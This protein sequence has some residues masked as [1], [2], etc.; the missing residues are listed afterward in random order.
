V[1]VCE[2][3]NRKNEANRKKKFDREGNPLRDE[4]GERENDKKK[5]RATSSYLE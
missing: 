1:R 2:K 4:E 5:K 3:K